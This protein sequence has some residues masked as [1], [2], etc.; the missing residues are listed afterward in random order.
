MVGVHTGTKATLS[1]HPLIK[2]LPYIYAAA[3]HSAAAIT[4]CLEMEAVS[5]KNWAIVKKWGQ[6]PY[7]LRVQARYDLSL[8]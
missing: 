5:E 1:Q 3:G 8:K 6:A 2:Q 7:Q 4:F